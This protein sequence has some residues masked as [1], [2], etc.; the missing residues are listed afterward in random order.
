MALII[1][2]SPTKARTFN[3]ILKSK[4]LEDKNNYFVFASMG[5]IRDLPKSKIAIDYEHDF[6][7]DLEP[8]LNKEKI[9]TQLK[10]L[11]LENQEIILGESQQEQ[12]HQCE[13]HADGEG[14]G[15]GMLIGIKSCERLQDRRCHL[16]NQRDDAYLCKRKVELILYY[17]VD[18][19][20]NRL[21]HIVQEMGNATDDEHGIHRTLYHRRISLDFTAY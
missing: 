20:N 17:R 18:G 15:T 16:E 2:E 11:A 5:H 6:K 14:I 9:I 21:N 12:A 19:R 10:K 4:G 3:Y 13:A 1:V 7:P 8:I